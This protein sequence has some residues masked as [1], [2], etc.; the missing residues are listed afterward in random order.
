M[1]S[2][3]FTTGTTIDSAW[4]NDVNTSTYTTV[5]ALSVGVG[6]SL[7]KANNLSDVASTATA[8]TN[9]GAAA[10]GTLAS[11]GITGAA[12]SGAN[13]DITS[14]LGLTAGG[15]PDS[16]VL[17]ADIAN[18]AVTPAK[19]SQPHTMGTAVATTSGTS[20]D[21]TGIPSWAKRITV[22]LTGVSTNG[23]NPPQIQIGSGSISTTGYT[24]TN[25][26][27]LAA[28][29]GGVAFA[30]G[31]GIAVSTSNWAATSQAVGQMVLVLHSGNTWVAS[32]VF[33][34]NDAPVALYS[35]AGSIALAGVLDRV[36]LTTV[37][38]TDTF[39]AGSVNIQYEG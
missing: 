4:L 2:K 34:R 3:T 18:A 33:G 26:V 20:I 22:S 10:S 37:G 24:G 11:S 7:L 17:T 13:A 8:R 16:S 12:A 31:F 21:F 5:P 32:G 25:A 27:V 35:T 6:N 36:R 15:L 14:L 9:L 38:S 29:A 28:T 30:S 19:L 39:D 23:I 1:T